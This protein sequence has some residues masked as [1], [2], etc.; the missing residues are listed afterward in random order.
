MYLRLS[1]SLSGQAVGR[2]LVGPGRG[3]GSPRR[4]RAASIAP[5]GSPLYYP[6]LP[7]PRMPLS[8]SAPGYSLMSAGHCPDPIMPDID[9]GF[10]LGVTTTHENQFQGSC[11]D[12]SVKEEK[13]AQKSLVWLRRSTFGCQCI[14]VSTLSWVRG[15]VVGEE[16]A[17]SGT[18]DSTCKS[19]EPHAPA[20]SL[21][22]SGPPAFLFSCRTASYQP[23][24]VACT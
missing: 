22:P 24:I 17:E 8:I 3:V 2:G 7:T 18:K 13:V 4:R 19:A 5:L 11:I 12:V 14:P 10:G 6:P 23:T 16:H 1:L 20:S 9:S 21:Q 15:W